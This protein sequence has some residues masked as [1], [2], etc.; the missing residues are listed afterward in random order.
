[1]VFDRAWEFCVSVLRLV[2][3]SRPDNCCEG[4]EASRM[5]PCRRAWC[6]VAPETPHLGVLAESMSP[7]VLDERGK[8]IDLASYNA[9]C[10]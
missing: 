2:H 5:N 4:E 10:L 3:G 6:A 7:A 9:Q 8:F 1:M